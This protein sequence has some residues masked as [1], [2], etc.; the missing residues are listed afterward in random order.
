MSGGE[1]LL[2]AL[3]IWAGQWLLTIITAFVTSK[4]L[5][6]TAAMATNT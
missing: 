1:G 5:C 6:Q 3:K 4:K 2:T